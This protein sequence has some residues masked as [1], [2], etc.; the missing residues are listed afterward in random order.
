MLFSTI[1]Q[2]NQIS[3]NR[4]RTK[5]S[6]QKI[7][8]STA[9]SIFLHIFQIENLISGVRD[10]NLK[11]VLSYGIGLHHA[12]LHERDRKICEELFCNQKIQV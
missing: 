3:L 2:L 7:S 1:L 10:Q 6:F 8:N 12:G 11:H 9:H 5:I 4:L